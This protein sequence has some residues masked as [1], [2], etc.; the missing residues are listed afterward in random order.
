M[1]GNQCLRELSHCLQNHF[2]GSCQEVA[3]YV[4][5]Q[6]DESEVPSVEQMSSVVKLLLKVCMWSCWG[7][8]RLGRFV[9]FGITYTCTCVNLIH[10]YIY[11]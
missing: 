8:L 4:L 11:M 5:Q 1:V 3:S 7:L 6:L 9:P 2:A 10:V